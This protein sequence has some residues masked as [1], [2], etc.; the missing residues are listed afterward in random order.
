[1]AAV[2]TRTEQELTSVIQKKEAI[3][4][5]EVSKGTA[6][7]ERNMDE[8]LKEQAASL[9][10]LSTDLEKEAREIHEESTIVRILKTV[11]GFVVGIVVAALKAL[12][13]LVILVIVAAIAVVLLVAAAFLLAAGGIYAVIGGIILA[14]VL[15]AALA[16]VVF[17]AIG[18]VTGLIDGWNK[19]WDS[20]KDQSLDDFE[21]GMGGGEGF[22]EFI[23]SAAV[24]IGGLVGALR[25]GLKG[26]RKFRLRAK[27]KAPAPPRLLTPAEA[28]AELADAERAALEAKQ[29][30]EKAAKEAADEAALKKPPVSAEKFADP[31]LEAAYQ[32]YLT[33]KSPGTAKSRAGWKEARDFWLKD[34]PVPRGNR[35]NQ[36]RAGD[37]P[38]NEVHLS[39]GKRLDSYNPSRG[40]IVSRKATTFDDIE[41]ATFRRYLGE[42][43]AKYSPGTVIRSDKYP[44]LDGKPLAGRQIL[45]VPASNESA[46]NRTLFE[47]IASSEG[48][49]IRYAAE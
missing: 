3:W 1:M 28:A 45:E 15:L 7:I 35:F 38:Y 32:L 42:L 16:F 48:I 34:G 2:T 27:P 36:T 29:A 21:A 33:R 49:L 13:F 6:E 47:S 24:I 40:E 30:A 14:A 44:S 41:E 31:E 23:S 17:A 8:A 25:G 20:A 5:D 37:Y 4:Q 19:Y 11:A 46:A 39:N 26:L 43:K 12:V 22:F 9:S 10:K 18:I